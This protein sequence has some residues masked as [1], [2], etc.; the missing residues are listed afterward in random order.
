MV[1]ILTSWLRGNFLSSLPSSASPF[2]PLYAHSP[3]LLQMVNKSTPPSNLE[4]CTWPFLGNI[5]FLASQPFVR[6]TCR[7]HPHPHPVHALS[8]SNDTT[9]APCLRPPFPPVALA[10]SYT[11]SLHPIRRNHALQSSPP[12]PLGHMLLRRTREDVPIDS[13]P[14]STPSHTTFMR[15][16][17]VETVS[18]VAGERSL[19]EYAFFHLFLWGFPADCDDYIELDWIQMARDALASRRQ[20]SAQAKHPS[21]LS[22]KIPPPSLLSINVCFLAFT[23]SVSP[24]HETLSPSSEQS[25][26]PD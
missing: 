15:L 4:T 21:P 9:T 22:P 23:Q 8:P 6:P 3:A 13:V 18:I 1:S 11:T 12:Q 10:C 26:T 17:G 20:T 5:I 14:C 7:T 2:L 25:S 24:A 19:E 16:R